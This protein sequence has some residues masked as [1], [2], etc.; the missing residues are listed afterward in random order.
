[1]L[2]NWLCIPALTA[3]FR[4]FPIQNDDKFE[5]DED[6]VEERKK[7]MAM[8]EYGGQSNYILTCKELRK[9]YTS[10]KAALRSLCL[11]VEVRLSCQALLF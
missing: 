5:E 3:S 10:D 4:C 2:G 8:A 7:V 11:T 1:M 6:C 9:Q